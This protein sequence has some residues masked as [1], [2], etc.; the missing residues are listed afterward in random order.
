MTRAQNDRFF[1]SFL[2]FWA[3]TIHFQAK[4][5]TTSCAALFI[6]RLC[7]ISLILIARIMSKKI[8]IIE[9]LPIF[10]QKID[11]LEIW[12]GTTQFKYLKPSLIDEAVKNTSSRLGLVALRLLAGFSRNS[13]YYFIVIYFILFRFFW[14]K[15]KAM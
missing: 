15:N 10:D 1:G 8:K 13:L 11:F 6:W 4:T 9:K 12:P 2:D 14:T 7:E 5:K 3:G